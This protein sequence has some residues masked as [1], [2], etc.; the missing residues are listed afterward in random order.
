MLNLLQWWVVVLDFVYRCFA[1][2]MCMDPV[3]AVPSE[4][5]GFLGTVS[6][7]EGAGI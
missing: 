4:S 1:G 5:A 7:H 2:I 6:H 3:N